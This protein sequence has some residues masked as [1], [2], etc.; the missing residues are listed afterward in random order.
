MSK[1]DFLILKDYV[2]QILF[3]LQRNL[4]DNPSNVWL[5]ELT[6]LKNSVLKIKVILEDIEKRSL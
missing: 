3:M 4:N 1:A 6:V 5:F 2:Q